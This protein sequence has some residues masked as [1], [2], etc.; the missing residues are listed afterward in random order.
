[1]GI[2][3]DQR[4]YLYSRAAEESFQNKRLSRN[5]CFC[6]IGCLWKVIKVFLTV[7]L[8]LVCSIGSYFLWS[9][10][11]ESADPTFD[12]QPQT[13]EP[14]R[15]EE[16]EEILT[17]IPQVTQ[18]SC[19][20]FL[21]P[22][23]EWSKKEEK[24]SKIVP[25]VETASTAYGDCTKI[26][27][28]WVEIPVSKFERG[29]PIAFS[30][31]VYN[32][33]DRFARLLRAIY[34]TSNVY[35]VHVDNKS[36]TEFQNVSQIASCFQNVFVTKQP[37]LYEKSS[38][39]EQE[40]VCLQELWSKKVP[41]N[42]VINLSEEEF[43]LKTNLEIVH[44]LNIMHDFNDIWVDPCT[45]HGSNSEWIGCQLSTLGRFT[46]R[47]KSSPLPPFYAQPYKGQVH[48]VLTRAMVNYILHNE[49]AKAIYEWSL[50]TEY[51][52]E[53]FFSTLNANAHLQAPGSNAVILEHPL[54][55]KPSLARLRLLKRH[56]AE[57]PYCTY[58]LRDECLLSPRELPLLTTSWQLFANKFKPYH[59]PMGYAC[60]EEWYFTKVVQELS[61]G[62]VQLDLRLYHKIYYQH[63][64]I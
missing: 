12:F 15:E 2:R 14:W 33:L 52:H 47:W 58:Y 31:M 63:L 46:E 11:P 37:V 5:K 54:K 61:E 13:S 59:R 20:R 6:N 4:L 36:L 48:V 53:I 27:S 25:R 50:K 8:V 40:M 19:N 57:W 44:I 29:Q 43:P 9:S 32:D 64:G 62:K 16:I 35:C 24:L 28:T 55:K 41:W 45:E 51:S 1:M 49:D 42:W 7:L 60:L 30:I 56:D 39:L 21:S 18:V 34:R 23:K 38:V 10:T 26:T 3:S 17:Q 22:P